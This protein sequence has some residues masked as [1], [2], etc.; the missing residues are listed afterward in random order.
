MDST[1]QRPALVAAQTIPKAPAI[2]YWIVTA[3]FCLQ[4]SFTAWAQLH[5]PQVAGEFAHLGFPAYFRVELSWAKLIGAVLFPLNYNVPI[6]R[7][8]EKVIE[9]VKASPH[10]D[11][12]VV[13][14]QVQEAK[15]TALELRV[16]ASARTSGQ[17]SDLCYMIREQVIEFLQAECP[18]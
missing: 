14:L 1:L 6:A 16:I 10:W 2:V 8:R 17:K 5:L 11:G 7:L 9:I 4:M 13:Q 15:A 12:D 3:L 18:S